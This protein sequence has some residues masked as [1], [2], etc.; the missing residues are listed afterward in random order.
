MQKCR[1]N[2]VK[3]ARFSNFKLVIG[4]TLDTAKAGEAITRSFRDKKDVCLDIPEIMKAAKMRVHGFKVG[5][6]DWSREND[7][8]S[9]LKEE[10]MFARSYGMPCEDADEYTTPL[11]E[12]YYTRDEFIESM[13]PE[14]LAIDSEKHTYKFRNALGKDSEIPF[15]ARAL[16]DERPFSLLR[17]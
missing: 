13:T 7:Y 17:I 11:S 12:T 4:M 8:S 1:K 9:N 6:N 5:P 14:R 16:F 10:K 15:W 3:A 2:V